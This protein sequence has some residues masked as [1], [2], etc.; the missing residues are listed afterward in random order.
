M[1]FILFA[2]IVILS[3]NNLYA[4]K[5]DSLKTD[6]DVLEFLKSSISDFRS[7]T[8]N[9]IE[10]RST[11]T[12]RRDL[13]CGG[14]AD[15]WQIMNWE[16]AD[17]NNDGRTDLLVHVYWYDYGVYVIMDR[18]D[19]TFKLLTLSYNI[20][21]KCVMAKPVKSGNQ[22][23]L[24][25][26]EKKQIYGRPTNDIKSA[27]P[28]DSLVYKFG[29]FVELN[30]EPS[31]YGI[32]SI[33]YRTSYCYGSCPVFSIS[34]DNDGNA[35]YDAGTYNPKQGKFSARIKNENLEEIL[36]LID[37][38]SIKNL[39][40]NYSVP[41]TDD[42]TCWLRIKFNDGTVKEIRDYGL[43]GTFGLRLLYNIFFDLRG[44][45]DWK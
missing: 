24:L 45:Q 14:I 18:G 3:A 6:K 13:N 44:N 23:L 43:K 8:L 37:Y 28:I 29:N 31:A 21:E 2:Y 5:I 4:N 41:W 34:S 9:P 22:T 10:L 7:A 12:L 27:N 40:N 38:L 16:K 25:F 33:E 36:G 15:E 19:G 39:D 1:K 17:F 35:I 42:Q 20:H 26:Y 11:E 32:D 30:R